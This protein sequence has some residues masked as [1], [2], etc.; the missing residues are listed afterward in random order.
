[1]KTVRILFVFVVATLFLLTACGG[2]APAE[3]APAVEQPPTAEPPPAPVE[4]TQVVE[5]AAPEPT[6]PQYAPFCEAAPA[7]CEAPTV[8]MLDNKYC[9]EKVPYAIMSV[10]AGTTYE[11]LDPDLICVDQMHSDGSLRVTCH[12]VTGKELLSY[13]V[14]V[15][16]GACTAPA[17]QIG[18]GQC[19]DGYG[20]DPTSMCCA[21]PSPASGD[22]C[23]TYTV[24][25][26]ACPEP[27]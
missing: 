11:S 16:N 25:L 27:Q 20:Y 9:I 7:G 1:M 14:K 13:D 15:C 3:P 10:P 6:Q 24:D 12:S 19:P 5:P 21:A 17:L 18:T 26:G 8:E 2:G 4:P 22:G 23:T